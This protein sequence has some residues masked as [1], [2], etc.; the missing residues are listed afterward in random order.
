MRILKKIFFRIYRLIKFRAQIYGHVGKNNK[1]EHSVY[2]NELAKVG[3]NNYFGQGT[4]VTN[5]EI[6]NY[7]SI[8]PGVKLGPG[9][10][11]IS[12]ITTYNK[13][14][15]SV[16]GYSMYSKKTSIG[17]DVWIGTNVVILQG[18]KVGNG[19]VIGA[20]AIVTKDV[21]DYAIVI[22]V[23]ARIHRYRFK[24]E[25]IKLINKS[26]WWNEEIEDAKI[27]LNKLEK[28]LEVMDEKGG[29]INSYGSL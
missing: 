20:G 7:C 11:S 9:E 16:L 25:Q 18:V 26:K 21:P 8:A 6:G 14:S 27:V 12:Y 10:H 29:N 22:G 1:F 15:S 3:N 28:D 24:K 2:I 19:A 13:I 4:M 5:A 17:N 23:P